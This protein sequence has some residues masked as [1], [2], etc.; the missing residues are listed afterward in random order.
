[1]EDVRIVICEHNCGIK[2][3][4]MSNP[5]ATSHSIVILRALNLSV[6]FFIDLHNLMIFFC[7]CAG[8]FLVSKILLVEWMD[9]FLRMV[10][11]F[12]NSKLVPWCSRCFDILIWEILAHVKFE[13]ENCWHYD[14]D[15]ALWHRCYPW[16]QLSQ[17]TDHSSGSQNEERKVYI[18]F[19]WPICVYMQVHTLKG[20]YAYTQ[21]FTEGKA[22]TCWKTWFWSVVFGP[23][24]CD[25]WYWSK[26]S[27]PKC[28]P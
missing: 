19:H 2:L 17:M 26:V 11:F 18:G 12:S 8:F 24:Y 4:D 7:V 15:L 10:C 22:R 1:M 23:W 3:L 21:S 28:W 14:T 25:P 20:V 16:W 13:L 27:C 6:G 9:Y 5:K